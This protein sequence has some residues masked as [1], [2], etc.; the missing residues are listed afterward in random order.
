MAW[1]QLAGSAYLRLSVNGTFNFYL[2]MTLASFLSSSEWW[3]LQYP[4]GSAL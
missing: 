3:L 2:L 4:E 1:E